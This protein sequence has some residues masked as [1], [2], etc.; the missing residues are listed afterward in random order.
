MNEIPS[1]EAAIKVDMGTCWKG[2]IEIESKLNELNALLNKRVPNEV[3][4]FYD[5]MLKFYERGCIELELVKDGVATLSQIAASFLN[6]F[7]EQNVE[8]LTPLESINAFA[9]HFEVNKKKGK[10][11]V[12]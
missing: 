3:G 6:E 4:Q 1:L 2:S 10:K 9:K 11:K 7:G 8:V 5:V 12:K